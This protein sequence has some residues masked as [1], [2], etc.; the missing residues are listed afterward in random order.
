MARAR[1]RTHTRG[2]ARTVGIIPL[3]AALF[4]GRKLCLSIASKNRQKAAVAGKRKKDGRSA[5]SKGGTRVAARRS[6]KPR[7]PFRKERKEEEEE[8]RARWI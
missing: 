7:Q 8:R 5:L 6:S 3:L 1:V 2:R 4:R